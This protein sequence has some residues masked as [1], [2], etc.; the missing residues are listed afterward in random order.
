L[1]ASSPLR[2]RAALDN[3]IHHQATVTVITRVLV[4]ASDPACAGCRE[5]L[6]R[7]A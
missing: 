4:D 7:Q 3:A 5:R 2:R 6:V 1:S